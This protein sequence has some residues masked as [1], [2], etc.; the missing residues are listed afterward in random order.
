MALGY[1]QNIS[2]FTFFTLIFLLNCCLFSPPGIS[3]AFKYL[4]TFHCSDGDVLIII[5]FV[6]DCIAL[7]CSRFFFC[8]FCFCF[9]S[10][11]FYSVNSRSIH[12]R[13]VAV[14]WLNKLKIIHI[15]TH[16]RCSR[17]PFEFINTHL[18]ITLKMVKW[19][20]WNEKKM[21]KS[22]ETMNVQ[23]FEQSKHIESM[24]KISAT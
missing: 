14:V 5:T 12:N 21:H 7:V 18:T 2:L 3:S 16:N 9:V 20:T 10:I 13:L 8:C 24:A 23:S 6:R 22:K 15:H 1:A 4:N 17:R 19:N 11:S